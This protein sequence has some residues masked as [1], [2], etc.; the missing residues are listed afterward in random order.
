MDAASPEGILIFWQRGMAVFNEAHQST[1]RA[2]L[3]A[4]LSV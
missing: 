4:V 2:I 3:L 1:F